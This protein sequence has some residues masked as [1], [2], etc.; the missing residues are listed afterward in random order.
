MYICRPEWLQPE[1]CP[2]CLG[3]VGTFFGVIAKTYWSFMLPKH[4]GLVFANHTPH[5]TAHRHMVM[6][7]VCGECGV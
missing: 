3:A 6:D 7:I 5:L 2:P 4:G 1:S